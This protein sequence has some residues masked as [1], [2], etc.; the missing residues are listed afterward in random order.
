MK[1]NRKR[2]EERKKKE[3]GKREKVMNSDIIEMEESKQGQ[4]EEKKTEGISSPPQ[5][6]G[7]DRRKEVANESERQEVKVAKWVGLIPSGEGLNRTKAWPSPKWRKI[8]LPDSLETGRSVLPDY[9][10]GNLQQRASPQTWTGMSIL[11]IWTCQ[12]HNYV[13]QFLIIKLFHVNNLLLVYFY[14]ERWLVSDP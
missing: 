6:K 5:I 14:G 8:L 4:K 10:N 9:Y 3:E 1:R 11:Q 2:K 7:K 12:P 13:I